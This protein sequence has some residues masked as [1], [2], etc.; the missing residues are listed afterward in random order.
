MLELLYPLNY[1]DHKILPLLDFQVRV[2]NC[3]LRLQMVISLIKSNQ[4]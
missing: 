1:W 2:L 4:E 3:L